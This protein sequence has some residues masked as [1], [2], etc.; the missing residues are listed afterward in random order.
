MIDGFDPTKDLE[1]LIEQT[2]VPSSS[3]CLG[4]R[5]VGRYTVRMWFSAA[6]WRQ[7]S[8]TVDL[9]EY[10]D[11]RMKIPR[12][13]GA[14]RLPSRIRMDFK[15]QEEAKAAYDNDAIVLLAE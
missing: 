8:V 15:T 9:I 5:M 1:K 6:M 4:S 14:F 3:V 10:V 2:P 13:H 7:F 11:G 12:M